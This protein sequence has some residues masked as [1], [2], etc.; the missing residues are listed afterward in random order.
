MSQPTQ[1]SIQSS[2]VTTQRLYTLNSPNLWLPSALQPPDALLLPS[3]L[4]RFSLSSLV[5]TTLGIVHGSMASSP[6]FPPR[7]PS[8]LQSI[9]RNQRLLQ[10][11]R[12]IL[13]LALPLLRSPN[14]PPG[15]PGLLPRRMTL[16]PLSVNHLLTRK[17]VRSLVNQA[18]TEP[19][20]SVRR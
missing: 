2:P 3:D 12:R 17:I 20:D 7:N 14:L 10:S 9:Q 1:K 4:W 13:L 18:T 15:S 6:L 19:V 8:L 5:P 16:T 11:R